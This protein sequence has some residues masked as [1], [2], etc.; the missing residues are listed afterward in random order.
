MP[1]RTGW[2]TPSPALRS[3]VDALPR[4]GIHRWPVTVWRPA[5]TLHPRGTPVTIAEEH[6]GFAYGGNKVRQVDVLLGI[7]ARAGATS[8]ITSAGPQSN[9]CRVVAAGARAVGLDVHLFLRGQ[10]PDKPSRNQVLYGLAA[11][12]QHWLDLTDP[13]DPAQATA[14][15]DLAAQIR[16][17]GG[18]PAILDVRSAEE[19]SICALATSAVVDELA[20]DYDRH[21]DPP[22]ARI[23][24][25]GSAGN[26]AAGLLAGLAA[27]RATIGLLVSAAA[28]SAGPLRA[29]VLDR[30]RRALARADLPATLVDE[31]PLEVTD[32][33]VGAG[34]GI[35]TAEGAAAQRLVAAKAG[36]FLDPTYTGKAMAAVLAD[37]RPGP[38]VF[39]DTGGGPNV[40]GPDTCGPYVSGPPGATSPAGAGPNEQRG[41]R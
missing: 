27:R 16:A 40:F 25:A 35:P 30:A 11:A 1:R 6:G 13:Y 12:R 7:A 33:F 34:H 8:V 36:I 9:L 4:A 17:A 2:G 15:A 38:V 37:E 3:A 24:V 29:A 21:G 10:P 23:A 26:T 28:G 31:V 5:A 41:A 32:A 14:M 39:V 22:P 20:A 19:G 18:T